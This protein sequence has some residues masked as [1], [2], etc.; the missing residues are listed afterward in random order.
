[1]RKRRYRKKSTFKKFLIAFFAIIILGGGGLVYE[2]YS[3]VYQTNIIF[4]KD[5]AEKYIYIPTN[6][7][8]S[9]VV[10]ILSENGLLLNINSFEWLA[11][12]KKYNTN[13]KPGRYRIDRALNN[14][15]LVNLLRSGAQTPIRVTFNNL[16]TKEDLAGKVGSQIEADS[17]SI[18]EYI[19]DILFQKKLGLTDDNIACIFLPNT[20]EFYWN[21]SAEEFAN[22]MLDEYSSFWHPG[23]KKQAD[24]I[25][26]NYYEVSILASI[27]EKEQSIKLDERSDI[28]GLYLNRLKK[29]MKLQSD[30]TVIFAIGDFSIRRVLKKDLKFV[31]P[32]NTYMNT[33]LPPGPICLPSINAIDAV[34]NAVENDYLFMCAKE[35][36]SGYHNFARNSREHSRNAKKYRRALNKRKIMR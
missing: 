15:E 32:Y 28:A 17:L 11:K 24:N 35:D 23:R 30:P 1:M 36:F 10:T 7:D 18:I 34:L 22:R 16:R 21:T 33:G 29:G 14:N 27:V 6:S 5:A 20:Y 4:T 13:I 2:L 9:Q 26:L 12:Q 3:R 8:F 19:S 31:S 25:K